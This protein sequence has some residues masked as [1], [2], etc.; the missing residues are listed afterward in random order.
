MNM[1]IKQIKLLIAILTFVLLN[2]CLQS[3]IFEKNIA[4]P[5]HKWKASFKPIYEFEI[6]DT[7]SSYT[8]YL[9]MRHTDAYPYSNIWLNVKTT[10]PSESEYQSVKIEIP[11]AQPDGKWL[12]RGMNEIWEHRMPMSRDG[13][14]MHF[15]KKGVYK[16]QLEQIMRAD[17]LLEV[18]SIG[19]RLEKNQ[20]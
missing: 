15:S 18:M 1:Y 13:K 11:L 17:P 12:G 8:M 3:N 16:I 20:N 14:P 19:I 5:S 9:T 6:N 2:G 10:N 4:I 7:V